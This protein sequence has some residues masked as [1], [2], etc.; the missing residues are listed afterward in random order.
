MPPSN[1]SF[2]ENGNNDKNAISSMHDSGS[3]GNDP[4]N[5]G[6][7]NGHSLNQSARN[8]SIHRSNAA[9]HGNAQTHG[10]VNHPPLL[11]QQHMY[12]Q[13]SPQIMNNSNSNRAGALRINQDSG[14]ASIER[15]RRLISSNQ[16]QFDVHS[17]TGSSGAQS[18]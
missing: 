10:N 13:L 12:Q 6:S 9:V 5:P 11:R 15:Q 17:K 8:R 14:Q 4:P 3:I 2:H 1:P 18:N 7:F 16:E